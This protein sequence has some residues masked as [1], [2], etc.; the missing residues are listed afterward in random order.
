MSRTL[1]RSLTAAAWLAAQPWVLWKRA[2]GGSEW[3]ERFGGLPA[4][5]PGAIWVHAASVGEVAAASPLVGALSRRGE[6]VLLTVMTPTGRSVA[7]RLAGPGVTVAFAPLDFASPVKTALRSVAPRALLVVE[8]ELWP[9]LIVE[10]ASRG[11]TVGIVNGRLSERS[12]RRYR[13]PGFPLSHLREAISFVA[14]RSRTDMERFLSLGFP[15]TRL[16]VAGDSTFDALGEPLSENERARLRSVLSAGSSKVV[17]FGSVRPQE[18]RAV[19]E[20]AAAALR[21]PNVRVV[22]APR[23]LS[24]VPAVAER[25]SS[26]GLSASTWSGLSSGQGEAAQVVVLD[27]MGELAEIYSIAHV[28]FVGGTLA[29]YGGHNPLEPAAQ[30]VPVVFG[31]HTDS[32]DDAA[33]LLVSAGAAAVVE[34]GSELRDVVL[35]LLT[36]EARRAAMGRSALEAVASRRGAV[37]NTMELLESR[38]V[39]GEPAHAEAS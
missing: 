17:V 19:V 22:I 38:G 32:C 13:L 6:P 11:A 1:Y 24:R 10:A 39:I 34:D 18:E 33:R 2:R 25:L 16:T 31:P 20:V 3:L 23:H 35:A 15:S 26:S 30:G 12:L 27:T 8:T 29:P 21:E 5:R 9:N 28:A 14:C 7:Q 4:V 37:G 36:D